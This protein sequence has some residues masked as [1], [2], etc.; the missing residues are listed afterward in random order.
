[1][2]FPGI[3]LEWTL[4]FYRGSIILILETEIGEKRV[5]RQNQN[6]IGD[7]YHQE[8]KYQRDRMPTGWLDASTQ[9]SPYKKDP[10]SLQR[11]SISPPFQKGGEPIWET[12]ARR[13]SMREFSPRSISL[14]ELSQLLWATQGITA[15]AWGYDFRAVPSAGALYPIDTYVLVNRVESM[16]AGIY[17][18]DVEETQ[19]V[20]QREGNYGREVSQ[21]ALGQELVADAGAVFVWTAMVERSKWKYRERAYRYIYMDAGHVGQNLY[22][23]ATALGL[24]CCTIGA[25]YDEEVDRLIGVDGKKEISVYMGAVGRME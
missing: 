14:P 12:I 6:G 4:L 25:F 5:M 23:A 9:P 7:L 13:R 3:C 17:H 18:Y 20:L 22:L 11:F 8:T 15:R 21:A 1:V 2:I 24:G 16:A 10:P 19:L